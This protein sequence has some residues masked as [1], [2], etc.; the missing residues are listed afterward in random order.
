MRTYPFFNSPDN[1][2]P[3]LIDELIELLKIFAI[4]IGNIIGVIFFLI[5]WLIKNIPA[6]LI[7]CT[8]KK[9]EGPSELVLIRSKFLILRFGKL[10]FLPVHGLAILWLF[11][12][13]IDLKFASDLLLISSIA[14]LLAVITDLLLNEITN[15]FNTKKWYILRTDL[16]ANTSD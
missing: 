8:I 15:W 6:F 7:G 10:E 2:P 13:L 14:I 3:S 11:I 5:S 12:S 9:G 1:N 16:A 4:I